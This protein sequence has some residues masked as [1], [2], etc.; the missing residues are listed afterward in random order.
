MEAEKREGKKREKKQN[1][2]AVTRIYDAEGSG[3]G[4]RLIYASFGGLT[5]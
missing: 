1:V 2:T 4:A 3:D 5:Y